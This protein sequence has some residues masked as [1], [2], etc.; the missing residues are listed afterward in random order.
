[1]Y[2]WIALKARTF[3]IPEDPTDSRIELITDFGLW[4]LDLRFQTS[5]VV[6]ASNPLS[7]LVS[8]PASNPVSTAALASKES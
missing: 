1:M 8:I 2:S 4:A 5:S 6:L 7:I 3:A